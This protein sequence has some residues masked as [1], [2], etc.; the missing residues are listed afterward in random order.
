MVELCGVERTWNLEKYQDLMLG[1]RC[2]REIR[3]EAW[4]IH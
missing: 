2:G 4:E 1:H 3:E